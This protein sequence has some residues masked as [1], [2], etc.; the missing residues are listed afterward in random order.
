MA[1]NDP[2][3]ATDKLDDALLQVIVTRL[4]T[5]AKNPFFAK[6]LQE[7]LDA[8]GIDGARRVLDLGCGTGV[9]T[10]AVAK[11]YGFSGQVLGVDLSP[12]LVAA[13][14]RI[15]AEEG[16]ADRVEFRSGDSRKLD[17]EDGAFDAVIAHTLLSHVDDPRSVLQEMKR[18]VRP[19]GMI[20]VFDGDYASMTFGNADSERGQALDRAVISG[21]VTSPYVMRLMPRM[22]KD[23]GLELTTTLSN[24]LAEVGRADFW[25]SAIELFRRLVP[26]SGAMSEEEA[27]IWAKDLLSDSA[28]RTFFGASNYYSYIAQRPVA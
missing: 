8:M 11:R 19:G 22:L 23:V 25:A 16:C 24:V 10:R 18:L 9:A 12:M 6:M 15:A 20:A 3:S 1:S 27:D 13:A 21:V 7:Y 14:G 4:E 17:L 5:R 26:R 2:F 28:N